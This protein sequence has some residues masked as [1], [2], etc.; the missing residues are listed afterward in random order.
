MSEQAWLPITVSK[1][2]GDRRGWVATI[3]IGDAEIVAYESLVN[4]GRVIV[5]IDYEPGTRLTAYVNDS[6]VHYAGRGGR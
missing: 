4:P 5:E 6:Q 2:E 1:E 3:K